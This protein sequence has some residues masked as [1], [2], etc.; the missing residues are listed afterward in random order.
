MAEPSPH[1]CDHEGPG[2]ITTRKAE[3]RADQSIG[4]EIWCRTAW[5]M[6]GSG[7]TPRRGDGLRTADNLPFRFAMAPAGTTFKRISRPPRS[8]AAA[9]LCE[10]SGK[11]GK[12]PDRSRATTAAG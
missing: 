5:H 2:E 7:G 10:R 9:P 8:T 6:M 12:R 1:G 4:T 3:H 11:G